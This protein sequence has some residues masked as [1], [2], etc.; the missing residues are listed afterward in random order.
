MNPQVEGPGGAGGAVVAE[1]WRFPVKSMQGTPVERLD[2]DGRGVT[3]DR[4]WAVVDRASGRALSA[5]TAPELLDAFAA[6]AGETVEIVLPGGEHVRAGD[7]ATDATLAA[8]LGRDVELRRAVAGAAS[9][10]EMTFDPPNDAA[11]RVEIPTPEGT[12]VDLAALHV[13]TTAAL[14]ACA[15]EH[16]QGAWDRRRFRPNVLAD[17]GG[18]GT[19]D[20]D[21]FPEDAWVG[22]RLRIG[23]AT[24]DVMMRTVRCAMPLRAQPALGANAAL[25]RDVELYDTLTALHDNHLGVYASV[26]EPGT[27][28][29]GDAIEVL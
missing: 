21:A 12:F 11:E 26:R 23:N 5:K 1:L 19:T 25:A 10:Y 3:G 14:A 27:L 9:S 2:V 24:F 13:L 15:R 20:A 18:S 22:R 16:P 6:P 4:T 7:P 29:V 8:W 28:H 17:T